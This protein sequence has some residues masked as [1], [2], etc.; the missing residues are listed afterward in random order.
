M[1]NRKQTESKNKPSVFRWLIFL[2][3][4]VLITVIVNLLLGLLL[5]KIGFQNQIFLDGVSAFV[6]SFLFVFS[7]GILAPAK[8]T[9]IATTLFV[10]I[11]LLAILSFILATLGVEV[12]A[13]R[14][15][16]DRLSIPIFQ[17]LGALYAI[18]L[19]PPF[20]ICG[21]TLDQL[22]REIVALGTIVVVFG[23]MLSIVGLIVGI[24]TRTWATFF[25]G[26]IVLGIGTVTEVFPYIHLFLRAQKVK[27][28]APHLIQELKEQS[29]IEEQKKEVNK[30]GV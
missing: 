7:A 27:K 8:H 22:W 16:P 17:I 3:A 2:P 24:T 18:F 11:V 20:T 13:E 29:K 26:V 15:M 6:F 23:G 28:M 12:F 30:S 1:D 14:T 4:A 25:I 21:T 5:I 19:I 10:T 9:K